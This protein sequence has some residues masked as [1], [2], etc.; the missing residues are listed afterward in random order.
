M[1]FSRFVVYS[2]ARPMAIPRRLRVK[3]WLPRKRTPLTEVHHVGEPPGFLEAGPGARPAVVRQIRYGNDFVEETEIEPPDVSPPQP[4]SSGVTWLDVVGLDDVQAV[5]RL[6]EAFGLH[7]LML[8]DIVHPR[9]R[10]KS[11]AYGRNVF[12]VMRIPHFHNGDV[13][14]EQISL[15]LGD[16]FVLTFQQT[17]EDCFDV[18]RDRIR[19]HRGR[20]RGA[21]ADYLA[22]A[23][24]DA[25]IDEYFPLID[26]IADRIDGIERAILD[27]EKTDVVERL[28]ATKH[29]L[30]RMR[31]N[32]SPARDAVTAL[33]SIAKPLVS[34]ET[35]LYL[36][37]CHDHVLQ[38]L[39]LAESYRE[40]IGALIDVHLNMSSQRMNEVMKV[41]TIIA[42]IFMPISFIAGLYGMNF[43]PG[44]SPYNM[45]ELSSKWGYPAVLLT[46]LTLAAAMVFFFWRRGW[47][48][49]GDSPKVTK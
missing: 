29:V 15:V 19:H 40:T 31:R 49:R 36:R 11:E 18:V 28:L 34:D 42:T 17:T 35:A 2:P 47:L 24:V 44:A 6:G 23:L 14:Y 25:V 39:E 4:G 5:G 38:I 1:V 20:V 48:G 26:E 30:G 46:M 41:L 33:T 27:M 12:V 45:P 13:D 37:D 21:G 7:P 16:G 43:D 22:Y 8:E 3:A 9:Q 32:L 10:P